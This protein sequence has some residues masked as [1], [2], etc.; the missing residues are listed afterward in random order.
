MPPPP[1]LPPF[2]PPPLPLLILDCSCPYSF[3]CS[4]VIPTLLTLYL[5][6]RSIS[7]LRRPFSWDTSSLRRPSLSLYRILSSPAA[8]T[9]GE[10]L[11]R[12]PRASEYLTRACFTLSPE[13][14]PVCI[15][16][17]CA[18]AV[19]PCV[20]FLHSVRRIF[21][22]FPRFYRSASFSPNNFPSLRSSI[23]CRTLQLLASSR[24]S[25]RLTSQTCTIYS[26]KLNH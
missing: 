26:L 19:A 15:L 18:H 4:Y 20:N 16:F 22:S 23:R 13:V 11:S 14:R 12:S 10:A 3:S 6:G 9:Y 24:K 2:P 25:A 5:R 21:P 7:P 1:F 17:C 8:P